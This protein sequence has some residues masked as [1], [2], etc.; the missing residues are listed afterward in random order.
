MAP[1]KKNT[2]ANRDQDLGSDANDEE[3]QGGHRD[4]WWRV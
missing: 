1:E 4:F 2:Q 3:D